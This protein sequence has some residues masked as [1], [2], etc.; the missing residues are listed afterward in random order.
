M[1]SSTLIARFILVKFLFDNYHLLRTCYDGGYYIYYI[2][3]Y[4]KS[5]ITKKETKDLEIEDDYV[6]L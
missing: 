2:L 5:K 3:F 4:I 6:I 1:I